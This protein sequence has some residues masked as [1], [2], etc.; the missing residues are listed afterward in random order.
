[1]PAT[2]PAAGSRPERVA[3]AA[4]DQLATALEE[5]GFDVGREFTMLQGRTDLSRAPR[6]DVGRIS[7]IS[8]ARL[9]SILTEAAQR[10]MTVA[11]GNDD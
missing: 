11:N 7:I 1:M 2:E 5:V 4:A 6:V 9:V 3:Q 10:G 8:A